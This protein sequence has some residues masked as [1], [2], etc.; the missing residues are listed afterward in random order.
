MELTYTIKRSTELPIT[1]SYNGTG[2]I[3]YRHIV[4]RKVTG[5]RVYR[6][7]R[8]LIAYG[9]VTIADNRRCVKMR[10]YSWELL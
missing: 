2:V 8:K 5:I 10:G 1:C 9:Y 3:P 6:V 4:Y 7:G